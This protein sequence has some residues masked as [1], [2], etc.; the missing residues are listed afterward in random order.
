MT[1]PLELWRDP[2]WQ[3]IGVLVAI[4]FG[5]I[6]SVL[7]VATLYLTRR[8][9]ALIYEVMSVRPWAVSKGYVEDKA[10]AL[11]DLEH[12]RN[13]QELLVQ[14]ENTGNM[15]IVSADFERPVKVILNDGAKILTADIARF[16]P[17]SLTV[18]V[19]QEGTSIT[20]LPALLNSRDRFTLRIVAADFAGDIAV[21]GRIAG[22]ANIKGL[23]GCRE[24]GKI[25]FWCGTAVTIVAW[26]LGPILPL[27]GIEFE[28]PLWKSALIFN[29]GYILFSILM[30][31]FPK[32]L[33]W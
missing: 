32:I 17:K 2:I 27:F 6:T 13:A 28:E 4:I 31:I 14:F 21:D 16:S 3:S 20:L 18:G 22:V 7:T 11:F 15:P 5:L 9:K 23:Q 29:F 19:Q 26:L 12:A 1:N 33:D 8:R 25:M 10:K 24:T 30:M